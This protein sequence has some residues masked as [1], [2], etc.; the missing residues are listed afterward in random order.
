MRIL[1]LHD[2]PLAN[3]H[4]SCLED[5]LDPERSLATT[6]PGVSDPVQAVRFAHRPHRLVLAAKIFVGS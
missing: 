3:L 6:I 2:T 1:L 5:T 4:A